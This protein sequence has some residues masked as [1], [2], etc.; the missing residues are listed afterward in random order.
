ME[1]IL[2]DEEYTKRRKKRRIR[3]IIILLVI[4]AAAGGLYYYLVIKNKSTGSTYIY[5]EASVEKGDISVGVE[6]SG[7]VTLD[8]SSV[9]Y[10]LETASADDTS[11]DSSTSSSDDDEDSSY[12]KI[13]K[14]YAVQGQRISEGDKLFKLTDA[15]VRSV[16]R[17]LESNASDAEVTLA[18]AESSYTLDSQD[19]SNTASSS[20]T[21][22]AVAQ[23]TYDTTV[24]ELQNSINS[25]AAENQVLQQEIENCQANLTNSDFL[26]DYETAKETLASA[27][28][29]F[30]ART[31]TM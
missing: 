20:Q 28:S 7:S 13:E 26:D 6:E 9:N 23:D 21:A 25:Y 19:A 22:A 2:I 18:E 24:A 29:L 17:I 31:N 3:T 1:D 30:E 16:R 5:K 14:V 12:L 4:A 11:E 27:K 10:D 8:E 15:S